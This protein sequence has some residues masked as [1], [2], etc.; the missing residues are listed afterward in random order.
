MRSKADIHQASSL[1]LGRWVEVL[2]K[3]VPSEGDAL[4]VPSKIFKV[5]SVR[6]EKTSATVDLS[7]LPKMWRATKIYDEHAGPADRTDISH[8]RM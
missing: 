8:V 3:K 1:V 6:H 2:E 5:H 7:P 4:S